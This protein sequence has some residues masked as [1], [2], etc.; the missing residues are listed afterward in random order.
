MNEAW[1]E[2]CLFHKKDQP[3]MQMAFNN[4]VLNSKKQMNVLGVAF[5]SKLSWQPHV[6]NAIAKSKI[7]LHAIH[8]IRKHFKEAELLQLITS[9][10]YSILYYNSEIWHLPSNSHNLKSTNVR[11]GITVKTMYTPV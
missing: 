11:I 4:Q 5:D 3:T 9:N 7:A 10:Y 8:L 6:A 1:T 2:L